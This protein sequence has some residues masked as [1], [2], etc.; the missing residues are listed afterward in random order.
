MKKILLILSLSL[1]GIS[2]GGVAHHSTNLGYDTSIENFEVTGEFIGFRWVNPH[3]LMQ[4]RVSNQAG[5]EEIW[6]A[7]T[8]GASVL[9][10]FGW[11]PNM[12]EPGQ[13]LTIIGNPPRRED[14]HIVHIQYIETTDGEIYSPNQAN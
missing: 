5:E 8:H 1:M 2:S 9:G 7:E 13:E 6:T 3:V 4:V 10:R 11:R 14:D 12:F